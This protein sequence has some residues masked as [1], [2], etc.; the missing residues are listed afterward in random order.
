M[1]PEELKAKIDLLHAKLNEYY[2]LDDSWRTIGEWPEGERGSI[3]HPP[4]TEEEI[5]QAEARF[6]HKFPP[7]YREFLRLQCGWQHC[8]GDHTFIGTA[9]PGTKKAQEKIVGDVKWQIDFLR[10]DSQEEWPAAAAS[11]E[12][13]DESNLYLPHHL[14]IATDFRGALWVFDTRTRDATQEMKLTFWEKSYGAQDPTFKDFHEYL[15]FAIGEVEFRL[16][17]W[18][19]NAKLAKKQKNQPPKAKTNARVSKKAAPRKR[20]K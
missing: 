11:W 10:E 8:W 3:L 6:G 2:D 16:E 19:G 14:V 4:A 18:K 20:S 5:R 9:R 13:A 17:D 15:D 1:S 7:S 12:A